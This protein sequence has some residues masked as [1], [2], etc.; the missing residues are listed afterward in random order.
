VITLLRTRL[1]RGVAVV[2]SAVVAGIALTTT[3]LPPGLGPL[4]GVLAVLAA[5][6]FSGRSGEP[7]PDTPDTDDGD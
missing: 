7:G 1:G 5:A 2:G 6:W 3:A 4:S